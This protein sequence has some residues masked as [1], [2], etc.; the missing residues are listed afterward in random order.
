MI[1]AC[2][3]PFRIT[4]VSTDAKEQQYIEDKDIVDATSRMMSAVIKMA[5]KV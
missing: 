3:P 1:F 5:V 2:T 4:F